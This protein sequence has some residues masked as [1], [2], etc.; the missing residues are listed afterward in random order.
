MCIRDR[1]ILTTKTHTFEFTTTLFSFNTV[2][3]NIAIH[4]S[5]TYISKTVH[6]NRCTSW[7]Q[8]ARQRLTN[9]RAQLDNIALFQHGR[10]PPTPGGDQDSTRPQPGRGRAAN[11][12][13]RT[14]F[15]FNTVHKLATMQFTSLYLFA[16]TISGPV[17]YTH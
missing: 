9:T 11:G 5:T 2:H 7:Q 8:R 12:G 10:Q 3:N 16:S 15:K 17:S 13:R 1:Y 4:V 14:V 6:Y